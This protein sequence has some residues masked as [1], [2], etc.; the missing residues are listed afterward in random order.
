[1]SSEGSEPPYVSCGVRGCRLLVLRLA[2]DADGSL[3]LLGLDLRQL[4]AHLFDEFGGIVFLKC[5]M[6]SSM[7]KSKVPASAGP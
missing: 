5:A 2:G 1:M 7:R 3:R 6:A 4:L